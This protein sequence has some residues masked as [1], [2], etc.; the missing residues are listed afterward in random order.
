MGN[1]R[2]ISLLL[3]ISKVLEKLM[4][5]RLTS[6]LRRHSVLYDGQYGFRSKR[7]TIDAVT[8]GIT[9]VLNAFEQGKISIMV[10]LDMSRAFDSLSHE[11]LL[12][13]LEIY[14]VRGLAI[15][16][17]DSYLKNRTIQVDFKG[18][19][20]RKMSTSTGTAQGSNL[21]PLLYIIFTNDL[22]KNL[23][24]SEGIIF[25]DDTTIISTGTS[26]KTVSAKVNSDL[27][28][29]HNYFVRNELCL[30]VE[31]TGYII[32]NNKRNEKCK[33]EIAGTNV[34]EIE[35][36]KLLGLHIDSKLSWTKHVDY[37][38]Q[39]LRSGIGALKLVKNFVEI[40][41]KLLI[42]HAL[43]CSHLHYGATLWGTML[44]KKNL[45][46]LQVLQNKAV[47]VIFDLPNKT[48]TR[49]VMKE[50]QL[51]NV[52]QISMLEQGKLIFRIM[53]CMTSNRI[54]NKFN[55][56]CQINHNY[57]T[58]HANDPIVPI[59]RTHIYATSYLVKGPSLW[60]PLS[61]EI[62]GSNHVKQF[63]KKLKRKLSNNS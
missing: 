52:S 56:L 19:K 37:I 33:I 6:W 32:F 49:N 21:G 31:K 8:D 45:K 57:G 42:Y 4:Y 30:N 53:N 47:C 50:H 11:K 46:T 9:T 63:G 41:H 61:K 16:W 17:F 7:G 40:K 35:C 27:K 13:K 34:C 51:L 25:A 48:N 24:Q 44:S 60:L 2:P 23:Y 29:L 59:H 20:S 15:N 5:V 10:L 38:V 39:K 3:V 58:R 26:L 43:I 18:T 62:K 1:Y 36:G 22:V 28:N 55:Q 54:C 12:S 14:G